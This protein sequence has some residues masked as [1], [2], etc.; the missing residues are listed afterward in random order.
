MAKKILPKKTKFLAKLEGYDSLLQ[1]IK[2]I[3]QKGLY[4]AYQAVDNLKVQTYWQ[5]GERIV[6]EEF[7]Q[8]DR[9]DYG[10]RIIESLARDLN[11]SRRLM[12]D[13]VQFYRTY[14]IVHA[15]HAQLSWTHYRLLS[16]I[17]NDEERQFYEIQTIRN[18]W[19][20]RELE[21]RFKVDEFQ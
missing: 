15:L 1:D 19:S 8:R 2:S 13:I 7:A 18:S 21:K 14:P 20:Y 6:R 9:A 4:K 12:F 5:I 11:F 16:S 17:K 10:K 3:L